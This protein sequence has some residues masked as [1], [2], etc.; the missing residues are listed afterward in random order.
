MPASRRLPRDG[1]G[2][3]LRKLPLPPDDQRHTTDQ[4]LYQILVDMI[5]PLGNAHTYVISANDRHGFEGLRL[6]T[7]PWSRAFCARAALSRG[8]Q[9]FDNRGVPPDI[10]VSVFT[11]YDLRHNLDPALDPAGRR[12]PIS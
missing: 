6:G 12:R 11:T 1:A 7:R 3:G 5:R 2:R 4:E 9:A 10:G 8:G